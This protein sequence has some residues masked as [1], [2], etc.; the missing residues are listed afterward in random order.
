[1]NVCADLTTLDLVFVAVIFSR[2]QCS[3]GALSRLQ[4]LLMAPNE[5][6]PNCKVWLD[7]EYFIDDQVSVHTVSSK[8]STATTTTCPLIKS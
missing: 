2:Q 4:Y 7:Y 1:M 3:Q 5:I 8:A 6:G